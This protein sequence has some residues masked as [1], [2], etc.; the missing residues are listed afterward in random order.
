LGSADALIEALIS[1][2]LIAAGLITYYVA[3]KRGRGTL[4]FRV[5]PAY[6]S[7]EVW[8]RINKEAGAA[9]TIT[10]AILLGASMLNPPLHG[11]VAITAG[12]LLAEVVGLTARAKQLAERA[13]LMAPEEEGAKPSPIRTWVGWVRIVAAAVPPSIVVAA[14]FSIK[15][16]PAEVPIHFDISGEPDSFV[17]LWT[18][19]HIITPVFIA[20]SAAGL[21]YAT[22]T[23]YPL[24]GYR[25]WG[26]PGEAAKVIADIVILVSYAAAFSYADIVN[27]VG[28]GHHIA[29]VWLVIL[30]PIA[31]V[32]RALIWAHSR[33]VI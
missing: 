23:R 18:F 13:S 9:L 7:E 26:Q 1:V 24:I 30:F 10:G 33:G 12:I 3:P 14:A 5:G 2:T 29:P 27:Y 11:F 28:T 20:I 17:D 15:T 32:A 31:A 6:A 22:A 19:W 16:L 21:A 4:G 8:A 25:P